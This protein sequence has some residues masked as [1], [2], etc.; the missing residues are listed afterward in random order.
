MTVSEKVGLVLL[1]L[2]LVALVA[3][4]GPQGLGAIAGAGI[5]IGMIRVAAPKR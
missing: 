3:V 1:V 4:I 5:F 2:M